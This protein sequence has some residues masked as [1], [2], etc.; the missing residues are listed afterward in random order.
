MLLFVALLSGLILRNT[1]SGRSQ[2]ATQLPTIDPYD[3]HRAQ[4]LHL[5]RD[6]RRS[7]AKRGSKVL[8]ISLG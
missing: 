2:F 5:E 4:L 8:N 7:F 6:G 1:L 3:S